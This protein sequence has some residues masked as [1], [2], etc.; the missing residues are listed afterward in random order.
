MDKKKKTFDV[1][2]ASLVDLKAEL[3]RK[4]EEFKQDKLLKEAGAPFKAKPVNKKSSIWIKQNAGVLDRAGKDI[5][6]NIEEQQTLSKSKQR[7]EEKAKL[8]EQMTHYPVPD[9]ETESMYLVDFTQK[10]FD[11]Q[12]KLQTLRESEAVKKEAENTKDKDAAPESENSTTTE[13]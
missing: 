12:K 4:Q 6:E 13:P 1:T 5:E 3:Y 2:A 10:I 9:E 11:K 7:L 8:Y